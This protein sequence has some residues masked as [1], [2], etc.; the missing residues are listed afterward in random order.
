MSMPELAAFVK[1]HDDRV[2]HGYRQ[3]RLVAWAVFQH[4]SKKRI[5]P[6]DIYSLPMDGVKVA[7]RSMVSVK[8]HKEAEARYR[9]IM[10]ITS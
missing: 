1:G 5:K 4:Q 7:P 8:E 2:L 10:N 3:A 9:R 6:E